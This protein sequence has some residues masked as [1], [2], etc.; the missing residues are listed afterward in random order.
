MP[1]EINNRVLIFL[2]ISI[3][4]ITLPHVENVPVSIFAF[5]ATML[6]WRFVAVWK[7]N[8]LPHKILI[9][10]LLCSG[11]I[12]MFS[13][14][15]SILGR[16]AGTSLFVL[17][18]GLKLLEIRTPRDIYLVTYLAFVIA[19][20]LFLYEQSILMAVYILFVCCVLL[21]TLVTIN[22]EK[23]QTWVAL[24]KSATIIAQALPIAA[25][26]FVLF[27]RVEAPRWML[28][29]NESQAKLGLND[30]IE[31]GS[32]SDLGLS[33]E[34]VF[35]VKFNG[36]IPPPDQRYW[37]GPAYSYTDGKRW[38]HNSEFNINPFLDT[39]HFKGKAYQYTLLMEPQNQNWVFAL[40][41]PAK[42]SG[43]I[44]QN[45]TYQLL[46]L[47]PP[48]TRAEYQIT[49]Y[50]DY[51]T[52]KISTSEYGENLQLPSGSVSSEIN[53]LVTKLHGFDQQPEV[54]IQALLEYFRK[55]DFHYTL[56]PPL[57]ENKPI[58]T[59]L[60]KTRY[61]FCSHY[62]TA[63]VYLMRVAHIPARVIGGYQGGEMNKVGEFLEVRQADAHAWA[64]VWL[65]HKG[66]VR[67]DPTSAVAP[68]RVEQGV[69]VERQVANQEVD[70]T[71]II[72]GNASWLK[73][74]QQMWQ[75]V[76]YSWQRWVINYDRANQS[77]FLSSLGIND[78]R[79][80]LYTM[81]YIITF[82]TAVLAWFLLKN[83]RRHADKVVLIYDKFCQK[84]A[85]AKLERHSNEGA[86]DFAHRASRSL[87][88]YSVQINTITDLYIQL[89][90]G[91]NPA[92][93][94]YQ[95]LV[96]AVTRFKLTGHSVNQR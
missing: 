72:S 52:G 75:T 92:P 63:F 31:P 55:E 37:R 83:N 50:P 95:Q 77:E 42:F 68:E 26:L 30:T 8:W 79:T 93:Q 39:P 48:N 78:I 61:G 20:S 9:F 7:K 13:Q 46:S 60:F 57:M 91:K 69:N 53:D 81:L 54:F 82:I 62:A 73:Q 47:E 35:R 3:G 27:P 40:D 1:T 38:T 65:E 66:W 84:L 49:S 15:R 89:R 12:L 88:E 14:Y 76:D 22:S 85:K 36:E 44:Q 5:F 24:K 11:L 34:L 16:D 71:P 43:N 2:L 59:F 74:A 56:K 90:Y 25:V 96:Q 18:M 94:L 6:V 64:E 45:G 67:F 28:F 41:M 10:L 21:A 17:A 86:R 19:S 80:M 23:P 4:L 87:P 70:F 33:P 29:K 51:N 58:E 32:I